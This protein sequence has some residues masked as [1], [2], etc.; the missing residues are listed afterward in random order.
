MSA[1]TR[2]E[3]PQLQTLGIIAAILDRGVVTLPA[4][5]A[6]QGNDSSNIRSFSS[7]NLIQ[8]LGKYAGAYRAAALADGEP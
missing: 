1:T 2:A 7:H 8:Q 4:I 5:A 3:F 6:L